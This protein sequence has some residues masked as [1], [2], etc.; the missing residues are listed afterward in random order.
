MS[1]SEFVVIPAIGARNAVLS[2]GDGVVATPIIVVRTLGFVIG[3]FQRIRVCI[4]PYDYYWGGYN[5]I[6]G[7][8]DGITGTDGWYNYQF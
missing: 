3:N 8:R 5:T 4:K 2:A 7:G 6:T 1:T